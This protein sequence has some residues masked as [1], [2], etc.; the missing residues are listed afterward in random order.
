MGGSSGSGELGSGGG[1]TEMISDGCTDA[2]GKVLVQRVGEHLLPTAQAWGLSRPGPSV[3]APCTGNGHIEL[4][5]YII[6]GQAFVAKLQG[7]LG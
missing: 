4:F 6:P 2:N 1:S 5:C 7:L 3:A